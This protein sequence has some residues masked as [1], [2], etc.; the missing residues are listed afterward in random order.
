[1]HSLHFELTVFDFADVDG[2][3]KCTKQA[4]GW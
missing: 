4:K 3:Y 2:L 1:M